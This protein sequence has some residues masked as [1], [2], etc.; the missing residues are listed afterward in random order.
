M[1]FRYIT[2]T[3]FW[4]YLI[5]LLLD[6]FSFNAHT[7]NPSLLHSPK[8]LSHTM[9]WR[10]PSQPM[11]NCHVFLLNCLAFQV[12][13][14]SKLPLAFVLVH[15]ICSKGPHKYVYLLTTSSPPPHYIYQWVRY[16]AMLCRKHCL[17][18]KV[19]QFCPCLILSQAYQNSYMY[20][21]KKYKIFLTMQSEVRIMYY[22]EC[23]QPQIRSRWIMI[24]IKAKRLKS[25]WA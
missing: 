5:K 18:F 12:M 11:I 16:F 6:K 23:D 7:H 9:L 21:T 24:S 15:K 2:D 8:E 22:Q 4:S 13:G 17:C 20:T 25:K 3:L 14:G 10:R 1:A 19:K